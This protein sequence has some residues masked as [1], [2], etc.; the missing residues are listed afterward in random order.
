M[1]GTPKRMHRAG[2]GT[3]LLGAGFVYLA[4][5]AAAAN[6]WKALPYSYRT[7]WISDL[8]AP[9]AGVFHGREV[10]S[11]LH[12]LMNAGFLADGMLFLVGAILLARSTPAKRATGFLAL[13]AA[14]A[15]G[16]ILVGLVP[17]T[18]PAPTASLHLLGAL[19]AIGGGNLAIML[20]PRRVPPP[21]RRPSGGMVLGLVG[22]AGFLALTAGGAIFPH[23]LA[24]AGPG[25]VE[26]LSVYPITA[27]E[28]LTGLALL[29]ASRKSR[30]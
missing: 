15:A 27:W 7:N 25:L 13:A 1:T 6:A 12:A 10:D 18:A 9:V 19:L 2:A 23:L 8:G 3:A 28:L 21:G 30:R 17:E 4:A 16:M 11:P 29:V 24:S 14:H 5:E 20:A 22:L 26:R